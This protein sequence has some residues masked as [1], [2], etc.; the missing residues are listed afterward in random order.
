MSY[1]V[2]Y[3][4][5]DAGFEWKVTTTYANGDTQTTV[6]NRD[7]SFN[8]TSEVTTSNYGYSCTVTYEYMQITVRG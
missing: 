8:V 2:K 5:D 1:T 6:Y 7:Q 4:Y 3:V